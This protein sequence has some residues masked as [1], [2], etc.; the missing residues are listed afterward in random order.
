LHR[1]KENLAAAEIELSSED[2][3]KI[4]VAASKIRI[5][6]ERYPEVQAKMI[7]R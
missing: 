5:R 7:D 4:E 2:L 1:L 3:S 6:G